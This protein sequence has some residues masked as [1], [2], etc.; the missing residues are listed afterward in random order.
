[1]S[2]TQIPDVTVL[3]AID[4][5]ERHRGRPGVPVWLIFE[6]LGIPRRSRRVRAQLQSLAQ[7]GAVEQRRAH[8]VDI[9]V[10][11]PSS[12]RRLQ[13]AGLV[14]LPESPQ[15][16]EWRNAR[17]LA[18]QEMERF[19]ASLGDALKEANARP[20]DTSG[21]DA[22]FE[23]AE[24]LQRAARRLGSAT[25]CLHEWMEP[26]DDRADIDDH[27]SPGDLSLNPRERQRRQARR[28][29]R[30]NIR[31]WSDADSEGTDAPI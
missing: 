29:G 2:T 13:G 10:L 7:D 9:W 17:T 12:R 1:M 16:R 26:D 21:S 22:W 28:A 4:R 3:A 8:G 20:S 27:I 15:H 23:L 19:R 31:L 11:A 25:Y 6:H 30:R 5:A 14:D 24:R 18:A